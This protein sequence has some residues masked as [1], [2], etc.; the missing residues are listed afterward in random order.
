MKIFQLSMDLPTVNSDH[1]W[2]AE[3]PPKQG[4]RVSAERMQEG[5]V[6]TIKNYKLISLNFSSDSEM[7]SLTATEAIILNPPRISPF[8]AKLRCEDQ[9]E[10]YGSMPFIASD[11]HS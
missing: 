5:I 9:R 3:G 2:E 6:K 10:L 7:V 4:P 8:A 1:V 11:G